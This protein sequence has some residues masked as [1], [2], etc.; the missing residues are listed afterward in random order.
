M[1]DLLFNAPIRIEASATDKPAKVSALCY[2]GGKMTVPGWSVVAI[3]L[4]NLELPAQVP[5]L[6]DHESK[7]AGVV[8]SGVPTVRDGRLYIDG[9]LSR[10]SEAAQKLIAMSA[11]GFEWQASIGC[12]PIES[13]TLRE[14]ETRT[15][16]GQTISGPARVITSGRLR[17]VSITSI[18]CDPSTRVAIAAARRSNSSSQGVSFM[19]FEAYVLAAGFDAAN[20]TDTQRT[21]LEAAYRAENDGARVDAIR[22]AFS[23]QYPD[24]EIEAVRG[25]WSV[26]QATAALKSVKLHAARASYGPTQSVSAID[27]TQGAE[28]RDVI[29][30]ALMGHLGGNPERA[31]PDHVL[32]AAH[33]MRATSLIDLVRAGWDSSNGMPPRNNSE[34]LKASF[35]QALV[36]NLLSSV[37]G[38]MVEQEWNDAPVLFRQLT[39][40]VNAS[41]FKQH[42][43]VKLTATNS[44][45]E[46][47]SETGDIRHG[48]LGDDSTAIT[49]K[50][51]AKMLALTRNDIINDDLGALSA[52]P[53][54]LVSGC[55]HEME[56]QFWATVLAGVSS[57]FISDTNGNL[58]DNAL[59][60]SGLSAA[61]LK[62]RQQV[63]AE[64]LPIV[65][66]PKFLAV[67]P[68][69]ETTADGLVNSL[70]I[71][72]TGSTDTT[73]PNA[74]VHHRKYVPLVSPHLELAAAGGT[75]GNWALFA[76]PT[77]MG[78]AAVLY[79]TLDGKTM[80]TIESADVDFNKLGM[81]LRGYHD[82]A[83]GLHDPRGIVFSSGDGE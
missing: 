82:W 71:V 54:V 55:L 49:L 46:E 80:P 40:R 7:L 70:Q 13:F 9:T 25:G 17:E 62:M 52:L 83:F 18:G 16:N 30:A 24:L 27:H 69:N 34:L 10:S 65:I 21:A 19:D 67:G 48:S 8:G 64:G 61:V 38:K 73:V 59:D 5:L 42:A 58:V 1:P 41:D 72:A 11:D 6:V 26:D 39:K 29:E 20:L 76:Q 32:Q 2:S 22:G 35:S 74:N 14:N 33:N 78:P 4:S 31:Y 45:F 68:S 66:V 63:N 37:A 23:G 81:Q 50:T 47:L 60:S 15:V 44:R 79:A 57:G 36:S 12:E 56:W 43:I 3:D 77:Q 53:E 28:R 51:Y 75:A